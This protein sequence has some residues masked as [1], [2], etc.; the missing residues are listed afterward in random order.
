MAVS[1]KPYLTPIS[2]LQHLDVDPPISPSSQSTRK[3]SLSSLPSRS[4]L[5]A[6]SSTKSSTHR[7]NQKTGE[8]SK[9]KSPSTSPVKKRSKKDSA[10][11]NN[12]P[13]K[14][15][16]LHSFF[17]LATEEQRWS[18][19]KFETNPTTSCRT[20]RTSPGADI[21]DEELDAIED[22]DYNDFNGIFSQSSAREDAV[23]KSNRSHVNGD[24]TLGK[25]DSS[26][27][28]PRPTRRFLLSSD[29]SMS[30]SHS[31]FNESSISADHCFRPWSE[32]YA[33]LNLSELA[34]HKKKVADVQHWLSEVFAGRS[35][36]VC[37]SFALYL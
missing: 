9:N 30:R 34:V 4:K 13:S 32:R 18:K 12:S 7:R 5:D 23:A 10:V 29:P 3:I 15:K 8:S 31:G 20:T 1:F 33:P 36:S 37:V 26:Q 24:A 19:L 17:Q 35:K 28:K 6:A 21:E 27:D 2:L 22:D 25:K 16:S 11:N 14:A